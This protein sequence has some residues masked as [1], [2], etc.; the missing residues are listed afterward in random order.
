MI[1]MS[2]TR[3]KQLN[4]IK[5]EYFFGPSLSLAISRRLVGLMLCILAILGPIAGYSQDEQS[6]DRYFPPTPTAAS[7]GEYGE[8]P[9]SLYTGTPNVSIPIWTL[10]GRE[11]SVPIS[12]SYSPGVKVE[13]KASW[14]GLGW[15]L[16]AG[17]VITRSIRGLDDFTAQGRL[18]LPLPSDPALKQERMVALQLEHLDPEPDL[19]NFNVNGM[20]GSFILDDS[21]EA[22]IVDYQDLHIEL[23][24]NNTF[25][26]V[27]GNGT[28]YHF[29]NAEQTSFNGSAY[30][31]TGFYLS[32]MVS[33]TGAEEVT[34]TYAQENYQ[35][36]SVKRFKKYARPAGDDYLFSGDPP[37]P[38]FGRN[39]FKGLRLA[40]ISASFGQTVNFKALTRRTDLYSPLAPGT[41]SEPRALNEIEVIGQNGSKLKSFV[42]ETEQVETEYPYRKREGE[43]LEPGAQTAFANYRLYLKSVQELGS[44]EASGKPPYSFTYVGRTTENKDLLPS[45]LSP[46]QD[47]WGYYNG[48]R[49]NTNLWPGYEGPFGVYDPHFNVGIICP[50]SPMLVNRLLFSVPG[51]NREPSGSDVVYGTLRRITYPTGGYTEFT[52]GPNV[53]AYNVQDPGSSMELVEEGVQAFVEGDSPTTESSEMVEVTSYISR[54]AIEILVDECWDPDTREY[55]DCDQPGAEINADMF[56][57]NSVTVLDQE[58][59]EVLAVKWRPGDGGYWLYRFG[60][61]DPDIGVLSPDVDG[62]I[63][64]TLEDVGLPRGSYTLVVKRDP[65][66]DN[67]VWGWLYQMKERPIATPP[68][69]VPQTT[70]GIRIE[71]IDSYT[72]A[73]QLAKS[74]VFEYGPGVL[75]NSPKYDTYSYLSAAG[76]PTWFQGDCGDVTSDND[77][78]PYLEIGCG[79]HTQLGYTKGS[80]VGYQI[81]TEREVGNGSVEYEYTTAIDYPDTDLDSEGS[82]LR[83]L[84]YQEG[85]PVVPYVE[86]EFSFD[87]PA[88]PFVDQDNLDRKRGFL[89]RTTFKDET[90]NPVREIV[91]TPL[92]EDRHSIKGLRFQTLRPEIDWLYSEYQHSTG[93]VH[94][95][96]SEETN[97]GDD[98]AMEVSTLTSYSYDS[99]R[100]ELVTSDEYVN[101]EGQMVRNTYKYPP[102]YFSPGDAVR[103]LQN[104]HIVNPVIEQIQYIDGKPV[105]GGATRYHFDPQGDWVLPVVRLMLELQPGQSVVSPSDGEQFD[106]SFRERVHFTYDGNGNIV[107]QQKVGDMETTLLWSYKSTYPV[108]KIVNASYSQVVMLAQ[109]IGASFIQDLASSSDQADIDQKLGVLRSHLDTHLGNAYLTTFTHKPGVGISTQTDPNGR[110]THYVYDSLGRLLRVVDHEGYTLQEQEYHYANQGS[111]S[112]TTNQ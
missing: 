106:S 4:M 73:G 94:V 107:Q 59:E 32:K 18:Q 72:D 44:D 15:S 70:A 104:S 36:Y 54:F 38:S 100:H 14:V 47:H 63:S 12:L 41:N 84:F 87:A 61:A 105:A 97:Y 81:V 77:P 33:A 55:L 65:D 82:T 25:I 22:R 64:L 109:D 52:F 110:T 10:Q 31:T 42:L 112:N 34:F 99:P 79:S 35:Y 111:H 78:F 69:V 90:G 83:Y 108:A 95:A 53:Y 5:T 26:I 86:Y 17:G 60:V 92:M 98:H 20:S 71:Q 27:D 74:K 16:S 89:K 103:E 96:T 43:D 29:T 11:L 67:D 46:A 66:S 57:D 24:E 91:Q 39:S 62:F 6:I 8:V 49:S 23:T 19:Y 45:Q 75:L 76:L 80:P 7:L 3:L 50:E 93:V 13:D 101:S 68:D 28:E 51:A 40:S 30:S 88:W 9:V 102:D 58:G 56:R 37:V 21:G 85:N 48:A 1:Y 2:L